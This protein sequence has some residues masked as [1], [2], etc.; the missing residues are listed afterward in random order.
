MKHRHTHDSIHG[1]AALP[2]DTAIRAS[3]STEGITP[4]KANILF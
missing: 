2:T 4:S 1:L 3:A